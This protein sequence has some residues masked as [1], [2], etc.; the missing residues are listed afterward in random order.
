M[1]RSLIFVIVFMPIPA[2]A[3]S[4]TDELPGC[5]ALTLIETHPL[6]LWPPP[7]IRKP[8]F[9]G[10]KLPSRGKTAGK[11][12]AERPYQLARV[13][14]YWSTEVVGIQRPRVSVSFGPPRASVGYAP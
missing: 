14:A 6:I 7:H 3:N 8:R 2:T 4:P 5:H 10:E 1:T 13:A 12:L 11:S 9:N